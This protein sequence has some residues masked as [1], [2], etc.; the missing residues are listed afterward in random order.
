MVK[1]NQGRYTRPLEVLSPAG[2]M[3][4]L[5]AAL[6]FGAD[7]VYLGGRMFGMR[8]ASPNFT[9][10]ELKTACDKAHA[11]GR[12]VYQTM[13]TL[14]RNNEIPMLE[15]AIKDAQTAGIDALIANDIGVLSLIKKYA[16]DMEIHISTQTGIVNY[17]TARELYNMG[18]KRVVLARELSLD[19]IAEIR[20]KTSPDMYWRCSRKILRL[21]LY[22]MSLKLMK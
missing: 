13:N 12:R 22:T 16:P 5:E 20:A 19:E 15:G 14:P 11:M 8:A 9:A 7:A 4:R 1:G 10:D 21:R 6:D 17:V 3:E 18:A 2:D